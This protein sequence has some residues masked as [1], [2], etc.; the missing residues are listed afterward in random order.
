MEEIVRDELNVKEVVFRD[1]EEELV[2]YKA[3]ANFRVLGKQLGKDMKAR[4]RAHRSPPGPRRSSRCSAGS[5]VKVDAG[6]PHRS[7]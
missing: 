7:S 4:G 6:G 5:S 1:N 3:K 2:E